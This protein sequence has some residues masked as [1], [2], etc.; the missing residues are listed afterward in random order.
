MISSG[1]EEQLFS[2]INYDYNPVSG[3]HLPK[4]FWY[5]SCFSFLVIVN[6]IRS[7]LVLPMQHLNYSLTSLFSSLKLLQ[8]VILEWA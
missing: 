3:S 4:C 7:N 5:F 6:H 2:F 8:E 1:N